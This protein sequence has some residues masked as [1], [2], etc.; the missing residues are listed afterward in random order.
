MLNLTL[1]AN[2]STVNSGSQTQGTVTVTNNGNLFDTNVVVTVQ[3]PGGFTTGGNS[4]QTFPTISSLAPGF[5][6][7]FTFPIDIASST[8]T[9][10]YP[11]NGNA[12]ST[13]QTSPLLAQA[14]VT[15][16]SGSGGPALSPSP[17]SGFSATLSP[18]P[19][20]AGAS[21]STGE[22]QVLGASD[23]KLPEAGFLF[24]DRIF[25]SFMI[26]LAATGMLLMLLGMRV[27]PMKLEEMFIAQDLRR[28]IFPDA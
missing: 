9:G 19:I 7:S 1:S 27:M 4:S 2:P 26:S 15:V 18:T 24:A 8:A 16:T 25:L 6:Q 5:S 14:D 10:S 20:V 11:V 28:I 12:S 17:S 13:S 21:T 3:L 22:G 23:Q